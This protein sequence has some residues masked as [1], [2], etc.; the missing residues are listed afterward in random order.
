MSCTT[1]DGDPPPGALPTT[2]LPMPLYTPLKPPARMNP[3]EDC[4][5]VLTV[6]MG[7][8]SRSTAVPASPPACAM[9]VRAGV[10]PV[11]RAAYR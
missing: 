10:G 8:K 5:R 1:A 9:S 3:W 6:S 7:K 2:T 11:Q 4:K